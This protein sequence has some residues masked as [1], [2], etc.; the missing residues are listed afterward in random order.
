MAWSLLGGLTPATI[1]TAAPALTRGLL[2][3]GEAGRQSLLDTINDFAGA[4]T[5]P[6]VGQATQSPLLRGIES[7]LSKLPGSSGAMERKAAEQG[8]QIGQGVGLLADRLAPGADATSAGQAIR[9]GIVGDGGF[10]SRNAETASRLYGKLDATIPA[11]SRVPVPHTAAVFDSVNPEIP[12]AP[13]L[14]PLFQNGRIA[15]IAGMFSRDAAPAPGGLPGIAGPRL[16]YQAVQKLRTAVG[17]E[18]S[19]A[20]FASDVPKGDWK[21]IYGGLSRDMGGAAEAAGP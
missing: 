14:T 15:N 2:R 13:N 4:G 19:N 20:T 16:P 1:S 17:K 8:Q 21:V 12:G 3:G 18:L 11:N 5:T 6:T 7:A 10:Q 9:Q